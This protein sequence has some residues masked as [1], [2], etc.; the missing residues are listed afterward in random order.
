M[1]KTNTPKKI[2]VLK[3][4][5]TPRERGQ[6]HGEEFR[7]VIKEMADEF[8]EDISES[9]KEFPQQLTREW[10]KQWAKKQLGHIESYS[11]S[12]F[13]ELRGISE[14]SGVSVEK[15]TA[16]NGFLDVHDFTST[17]FQKNFFSEKTGGCTA[18]GIHDQNSKHCFVGQN[19]DIQSYFE[20]GNVLLHLN[21]SDDTPGAVVFTTAGMLGW[22][23]MNSEGIAVVIN[24]LQPFD[25]RDG[26]PYP[27]ILRKILEASDLDCATDAVLTARRASG[28]NFIIGSNEGLVSLETS[29]TEHRTLPIQENVIVHANHFV[30][31]TMKK[32]EA[33]SDVGMKQ[34]I[35]R[36][37]K[38]EQLL[39][40]PNEPFSV[41]HFQNILSDRENYPVGICRYNEE[42]HGSLCGKT[43]SGMVF[44][45]SEKR[46]WSSKG[47][48][49]TNKLLEYKY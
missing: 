36:Q 35:A 43:V 39:R 32:F 44:E 46:M 11:K 40:Q 14:G 34:S 6:Q 10:S 48:P 3:L 4:S 1:E 29:A 45:I 7:S 2:P 47:S 15:M 19:Y 49:D 17:K 18:F 37:Q 16:F 25:A 13:D 26:V 12:L 33:R 22:T 42:Y 30:D 24:N 20:K 5:G 31:D 38:M 41:D 9:T 23:G 21:D 8:F 27:F 28:M